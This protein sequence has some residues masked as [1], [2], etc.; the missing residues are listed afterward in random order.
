MKYEM[1]G[2]Y[3][4]SVFGEVEAN[5]EKEAKEKFEKVVHE[6]IYMDYDW[7]EEVS[8]DA[9]LVHDYTHKVE[10]T[11][12]NSGFCYKLKSVPI[13]ICNLDINPEH[14]F[15]LYRAELKSGEYMFFLVYDGEKV[16]I[17]FKNNCSLICAIMNKEYDFANNSMYNV[18]WCDEHNNYFAL[19]QYGRLEKVCRGENFTTLGMRLIEIKKRLTEEDRK[20]AILLCYSGTGV[21]LG[22]SNNPKVTI[23]A[24]YLNNTEEVPVTLVKV[25]GII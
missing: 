3:T 12:Y 11:I 9:K 20:N 14:K 10:K 18:T 7:I 2:V 5:S 23:E 6:A 13:L 21:T 8:C 19:T 16:Y 17:P 4:I 15:E 22:L 24:M 25:E 1:G